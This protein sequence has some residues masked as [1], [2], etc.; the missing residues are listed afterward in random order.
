VGHVTSG[1]YGYHVGTS[2]AMAMVA[3]EALEDAG[4][5]TVDVIGEPV[6]ARLLAEPAYDPRGTRI[7]S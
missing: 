5:F 2:L 1:A 6:A 7:R 4:G 3:A